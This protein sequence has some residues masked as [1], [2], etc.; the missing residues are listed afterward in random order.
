MYN[1]FLLLPCC[2]YC[3]QSTPMC[4][5][6]SCVCVCDVHLNMVADACCS[7]IAAAT[8]DFVYRAHNQTPAVYNLLGK[9]NCVCVWGQ[10]RKT[11]VMWPALTKQMKIGNQFGENTS[12]I[13]IFSSHLPHQ[14]HISEKDISCLWR[15]FQL[16]RE[17]FT[18][19]LVR[20]DSLYLA[21]R[22]SLLLLY[23]CCCEKTL[24]HSGL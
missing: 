5:N 7:P 20:G 22:I 16:H 23:Y 6:I 10:E 2:P 3:T 17:Y 24:C 14:L 19:V 11:S 1:S 9:K 13:P 15:D 12:S 8:T 21:S 18:N 4:V